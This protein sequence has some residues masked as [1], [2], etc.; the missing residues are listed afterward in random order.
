MKAEASEGGVVSF[1]SGLSFVRRSAEKKMDPKKMSEEKDAEREKR[2][3]GGG[4]EKRKT[5]HWN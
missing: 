1:L 4:G 5:D 3:R 2:R